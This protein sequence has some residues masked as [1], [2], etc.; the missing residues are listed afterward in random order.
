MPVLGF[1]FAEPSGALHFLFGE[2]WL[3]AAPALRVMT[4]AMAIG[5]IGRLAQWVSLATGGTARQ[6]A[7]T[8]RST[9]VFL[10]CVV[11][12]ALQGPYGAALGVLAANVCTSIPSVFYVL[13]PTPVRPRDVFGVWV[14]PLLATIAAVLLL[15][16]LGDRLPDAMRFTG[17]VVRGLL[18]VATY[19]LVFLLFPAGRSMIR[20]LRR[21]P[22]AGAAPPPAGST[23]PA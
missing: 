11:I 21:P 18:F 7:W 10:A 6:L 12:G 22:G 5:S 4:V 1:L 2:K 17:L 15:S 8:T 3:R 19:A 20:D 9:P 14:V 23:A 16:V 13:R